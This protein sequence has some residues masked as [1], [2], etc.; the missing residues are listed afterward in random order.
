MPAVSCESCKPVSVSACRG[1]RCACSNG[2]AA[3]AGQEKQGL[4]ASRIEQSEACITA[5]IA[6]QDCRSPTLSQHVKGREPVRSIPGTQ[7]STHGRYSVQVRRPARL[8][9]AARQECRQRDV[10]SASQQRCLVA[11]WALRCCRRRPRWPAPGRPAPAWSG[12]G[13]TR[14]RQQQTCAASGFM[15]AG[16]GCTTCWSHSRVAGRCA[17]HRPQP[18]RQAQATE[19]AAMRAALPPATAPS[20]A[21]LQRLKQRRQ[22]GPFLR[23]DEGQVL[24]AA[25]AAALLAAC[26]AAAA[27]LS[28]RQCIDDRVDI[29][30]CS[31]SSGLRLPVLRAALGGGAAGSDELGGS[32]RAAACHLHLQAVPGIRGGACTRC[33][34]AGRGAVAGPAGSQ[35]PTLA[36][37][38]QHWRSLHETHGRDADCP[39]P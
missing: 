39:L 21:M 23:D 19:A 18:V 4:P 9:H 37:M 11:R 14:A 7:V 15:H 1:M 30:G 32:C 5:S 6:H 20:P 27:C 38:L 12:S 22:V 28:C 34:W 26:L 3:M 31:G 16:W 36:H 13:S 8:Q 29:A 35:Q 2:N 24:R 17:S 33:R 10:A 25:A